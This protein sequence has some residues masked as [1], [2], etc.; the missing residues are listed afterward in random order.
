MVENHN[1]ERPS[2][3]HTTSQNDYEGTNEAQNDEFIREK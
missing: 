2:S 1:N 3:P